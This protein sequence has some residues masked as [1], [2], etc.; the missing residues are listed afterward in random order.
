MNFTKFK[1]IKGPDQLFY[2]TLNYPMSCNVIEDEL[3][4]TLLSF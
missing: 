3:F 4:Y 1:H 2:K